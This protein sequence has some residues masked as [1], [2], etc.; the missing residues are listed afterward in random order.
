MRKF[1]GNFDI[2]SACAASEEVTTDI[3]D[4]APSLVDASGPDVNRRD[5]GVGELDGSIP[6]ATFRS[7]WTRRFGA[8][9][10]QIFFDRNV[11]C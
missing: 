10:E 4:A 8:T 3:A 7:R 1:L 5:A 11:L 6:D 2:S 9:S